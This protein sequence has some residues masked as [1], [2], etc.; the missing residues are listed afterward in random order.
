MEF[1]YCYAYGRLSKEDGDKVE[2]DSIKN[3]RDLI[4]SY[5][6]RHPDMKLVMEGFD[7]GYTGIN[8]ERP[9]F[10]EM[11]EAVKGQ[12]VNCVIVKDLS[13]FGREHIEAG[14]YI[15]KLF[16]ALG[17][18]FIAINDG[19]DTANLDASSSLLLPF[20]NLI[21]DSYCR[22]TSIKIRSHFDIKRRNGDFI[23]SFAAFGYTKSPEN[24]NKLIIDPEAAEV[25]RDIFRRRIAGMSCQGIADTLNAL[26][27]LSPME[28]K[29]SKGMNYQS[30][31]RVHSKPKWSATG[32]RRILQNEV[33]IGVMEQGKRTTPNYKVKTVVHRPPEEW[34]R[35]EN[36]HES[37]VSR[38]DFQL[39]GR[40]MRTDTRT[41]PGGKAVHPFAGILCCGDCRG[42]MVRKTTYYEG[43][44]AYHYYACI[45]HRA[46]TS[47][48]TPHTISEKKLEQAVLEGV[49]LHIRTVV[50]LNEALAAI[51]RRPLRKVAAEKLNQRLSV[52]HQEL[53]RKQEIRDSLYRRYAAGEV[54]KEDF[55][56]FKRIFTHDCE[57][58]EQS[59]ETQ[60]REL[61]HMLESSTP[62][63][64]WIEHFRQFGQ[65]EVLTR[66]ALVR[67]VERI[68]V[69]EGGRIE[70]VFRYQEQFTSAM[71]VFSQEET[72]P[73][74]EVV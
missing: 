69:Y 59:I 40:L 14:R 60:R 63:S 41:A 26:G 45:T 5:I 39:V 18:R 4:E 19:Y 65:L 66:E 3:Q 74:R 1:F 44:A 72:I 64:P 7:D 25:V 58:V 8:F 20:K 35:V 57:E 70:I 6:A 9:H 53:S 22:D 28:Y 16:P 50:E 54:S 30:G 34:M 62:N 27:V 15:E 2:S 23:G 61:E 71:A 56:E 13:R 37:I 51:A 31:Y 67:L 21:N 17:V 55:Y 73:L 52:L 42:G 24:K 11:L 38:E 29:R 12:K 49:N 48:C 36:V 43:R 47:V 68:L 32:V 33:Y 46:D 10:K